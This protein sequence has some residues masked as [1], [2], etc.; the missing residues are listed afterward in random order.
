M[1]SASSVSASK[2][3]PLPEASD[4]DNSTTWYDTIF[5]N[6]TAV[7]EKVVIPPIF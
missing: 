7:V 1:G 3:L 5:S 2:S 4:F 6:Y